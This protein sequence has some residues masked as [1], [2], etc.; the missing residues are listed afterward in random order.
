MVS[1]GDVGKILI[2]LVAW[3]MFLFTILGLLNIIPKV[4]D[5]ADPAVQNFIIVCFLAF[6]YSVISSWHKRQE[7]K[8]N[9]LSDKLRL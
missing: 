8:R 6:I 4:Y 1:D 7:E 2:N 9:K 5:A 3:I